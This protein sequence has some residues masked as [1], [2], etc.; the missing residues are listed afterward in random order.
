MDLNKIITDE[1]R[2]AKHVGMD[3]N[4]I[5]TVEQRLAKHVGMDLNKIITVEQRLAKHVGMDLNK[6][7]KNSLEIG[8]VKRISISGK[9]YYKTENYVAVLRY[10]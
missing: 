8:D 3:L 9:A 1:Q 6:I 5:V 7:I 2:L 4:K 10:Y